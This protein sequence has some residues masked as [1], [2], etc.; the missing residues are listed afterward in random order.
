MQG[1][2][3]ASLYEENQMWKYIL[4]AECK[5][6]NVQPGGTSANNSI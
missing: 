5:I 6:V 4:W 2:N 3:L 1:N